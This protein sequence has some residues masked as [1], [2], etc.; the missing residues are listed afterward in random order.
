MLFRSS[1]TPLAAKKPYFDKI[2]GCGWSK[3]HLGTYAKM[4]FGKTDASALTLSELMKFTQV[5]T[6]QTFDQVFN[7]DKPDTV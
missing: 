3:D 6:T 1:D 4:V 2:K 7:F 5:V